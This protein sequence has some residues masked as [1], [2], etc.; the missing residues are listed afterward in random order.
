MIC[1]GVQTTLVVVT[2]KI[3]D[4]ILRTPIDTFSISRMRWPHRS[5]IST[6]NLLSSDKV[7][8]RFLVSLCVRR[9]YMYP[10]KFILELFGRERRIIYT[11][12]SIWQ[13][14]TMQT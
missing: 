7:T 11:V 14:S 8:I 5:L 12:S 2:N 6:Q 3:D 13:S 4:W 1:K 10:K 9:T